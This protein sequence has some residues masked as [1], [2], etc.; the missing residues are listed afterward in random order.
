MSPQT[1]FPW[2]RVDQ[3]IKSVFDTGLKHS[4]KEHAAPLTALTIVLLAGMAIGGILIYK[5]HIGAGT[6]IVA[7][8]IVLASI[9]AYR[10]LQVPVNASPVPLP[11][12]ADGAAPAKRQQFQQ[13][14]R[15]VP[16]LAIPEPLR[17]EIH[18]DLAEVRTKVF[19]LLVDHGVDVK[20]D[21]VRANIFLPHTD[22]ADS[23]VPCTL[24]IPRSLQSNMSQDRD[25]SIV[26]QPQQGLTGKV[27]CHQHALGAMAQR[28]GM[29]DRTEWQHIPVEDG[30]GSEEHEFHLTD[31]QRDLIRGDLEWIV[32]IPLKTA[33]GGGDQL[34]T[35]GVLNVDCC[36]ATIPRPMMKLIAGAVTTAALT[37][38]ARFADHPMKRLTITLEEINDAS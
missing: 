1:G 6:A 13:W 17:Q 25:R 18:R 32:G 33:R 15:L 29:S 14:I 20:K 10:L 16:S 38:S 24:A 2:Y 27:Y 8:A 37:I 19:A 4:L 7:L 23:G 35:I 5:D 21:A 31:E 12:P 28:S 11:S 3:T 9:L 22:D 26:F 30:T 36:G 34:E